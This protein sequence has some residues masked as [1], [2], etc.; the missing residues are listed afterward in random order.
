MPAQLAIATNQRRHFLLIGIRRLSKSRSW[1]TQ[2]DLLADLRGQG[3]DV[4]KYHVLRDLKALMKIH[5]ELERHDD[6]DENG[7]P[8]L[9]VDYG[10]RWVSK[11]PLPE[12][13]LSIPEAISL[14][15]VARHLKQALPA[16]LSGALSSLFERAEKTLDLQQKN[17]VAQWKD[18]VGIV[19][20]S[21]PLLPPKVS[22]EVL[23]VIHQSLI[24]KELFTGVYRN[25]NGTQRE[26]LLHPLGIMVREPSVYL[27]AISEGHDEPRQF[28]MHRFISAKRE[29]RPASKSAGFSLSIY[30]E[31]QGHFGL[32]NMIKLTGR[33]S[34]HLSI[35]LDETPLGQKQQL[36]EPDSDGWRSLVVKLRDNWQL[37]WWLLAQGD[38]IVVESPLTIRD[39]L[40]KTA[41]RVCEQYSET[42]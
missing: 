40:V 11:D 18:M 24:A 19:T 35:I 13:G 23:N 34:P 8:K 17:G 32:G 42:R 12:T 4:Q 16:T 31:S 10:Y 20:P 36:G 9:G 27:V 22:E 3:F 26:L 33:V 37:R 29:N 7:V 30:L 39:V 21:Q 1:V 25:S 38:R 28:A 2:R 15:L 5:T 6:S 14:V 41:Q